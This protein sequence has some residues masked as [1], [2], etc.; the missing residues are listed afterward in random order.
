MKKINGDKIW[1]IA[2]VLLIVLSVILVL[3]YVVGKKDSQKDEFDDGIERIDPDT[4]F[5]ED[6]GVEVH[7]S[8]VLLSDQE[9]MRKLIVSKQTATVET[10][11]T[12]RMVKQLDIS[13][14]K[15]TQTVHYE[16]TGSFVVDLDQLTG[17]S[18]VQDS[19]AKTVTIRI[20]HAELDS[21]D[22]NPNNIII[23]QVNKGL[24][25][26]GDLEMSV[27]DF[28]NVEKELRDKLE[29]QFNTAENGQKA[30]DIALK[31]VKEI[32]EPLVKAIDSRYSVIVE[33]NS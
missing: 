24:L 4:I 13:I 26:W 19:D 16:G 25:A 6:S 15:K 29:A 17:D 2:S 21:I 12:E 11:L 27:K 23:D 22:I 20:P 8:D 28:N 3:F 30:D 5:L 18:I 33:F 10:E 32:Y 14:L 1:K 9:E 31:K 7:F